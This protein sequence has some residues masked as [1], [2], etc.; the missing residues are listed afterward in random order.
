MGAEAEADFL[1][2]F[3]RNPQKELPERSHL[4]FSFSLHSSIIFIILR[5]CG[6]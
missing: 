6:P 2:E 1:V 3:S 4:L 5:L